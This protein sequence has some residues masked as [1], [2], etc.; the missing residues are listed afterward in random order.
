MAGRKIT[1]A[2]QISSVTHRST[3][4][5]RPFAIVAVA[6]MDGPVEVFVWE[7]LLSQTQSLWA[8]GNFIQ[9]SG[10]VR[11]RG[12]RISINA[13]D[14]AEY[15]IGD[16][17]PSDEHDVQSA[18][19]PVEEERRAPDPLPPEPVDDPAPS[20][21]ADGPAK[22]YES[23]GPTRL[24]LLIRESDRPKDDQRLF[25]DVKRLLLENQGED[26]VRLE[27][28]SNGRLFTLDWPL[29]RVNASRE[30]EGD[31]SEM[32]GQAG[33]VTLESVAG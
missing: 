33:R 25:D 13:S 24:H 9:V 32:L 29:V 8:E 3:R 14:A 2:G 1:L 30:L 20:A 26:E 4:K 11:T 18:A 28:S 22:E 15:A 31:L 21:V 16:V 7:E 10:A 6:L 19:E 23:N 17:S 5:Q 12:D 27:I